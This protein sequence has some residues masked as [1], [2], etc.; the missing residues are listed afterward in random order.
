MKMIIVQVPTNVK[1]SQGFYGLFFDRGWSY[2]L[3]DHGTDKTFR[4]VLIDQFSSI[5]LDRGL[6]AI[7]SGT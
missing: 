6:C 7:G 3:Q 1:P 4:Q 2:H 5:C